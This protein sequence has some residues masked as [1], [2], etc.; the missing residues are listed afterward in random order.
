M[1][2]AFAF[3]LTLPAGPARQEFLRDALAAL[4]GGGAAPPVVAPE[5][6]E[7]VVEAAAAPAPA[8]AAPRHDTGINFACDDFRR[9]IRD[10]V[11]PT[12]LP[13]FLRTQSG[14]Y[15]AKIMVNHLAGG[16]LDGH[17]VSTPRPEFH[18]WA[19]GKWTSP[20]AFCKAQCAHITP[21]HPR[22]TK[23]ANGWAWVR[24]GN[25]AGPTMGEIRGAYR[26]DPA[27]AA[28]RVAALMPA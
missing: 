16:A 17:I 10:G 2:A 11:F 6:V 7:E 13:L 22:P 14:L 4:A 26:A 23:G 27:G 25:A 9:M 15:E 3:S 12:G 19:G 8:P 18:G 21:Q 24:V 1:E 20:S 5:E 28:A